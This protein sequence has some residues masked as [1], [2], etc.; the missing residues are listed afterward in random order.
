MW[1][2]GLNNEFKLIIPGFH[3][4]TWRVWRKP[5]IIPCL[6]DGEISVRTHQ[7]Y[8][9]PI[10][11]TP[12][13]LHWRYSHPHS[14]LPNRLTNLTPFCTM[15]SPTSSG[16]A[17]P[18]TPT[19]SIPLSHFIPSSVSANNF[20]TYGTAVNKPTF[21]STWFLSLAA[22]SAVSD[23]RIT[24]PAVIATV[25]GQIQI[26]LSDIAERKKSATPP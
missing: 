25:G 22:L 21:T 15:S 24:F 23:N 8:S 6:V 19:I 5:E 9:I 11:I 1:P 17:A 10:S 20:C 13:L 7:N 14:L 2:A 4:E 3:D 12:R 18:P 16:I 26:I